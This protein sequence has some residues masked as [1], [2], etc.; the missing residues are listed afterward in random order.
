LS[1][2]LQFG[3]KVAWTAGL[4]SGLFGGLVGNQGGIRSAALLG[5]QLSKAE[6]V[7]TATAIGIIVD[8]ARMPVYFATRMNDLLPFWPF[9]AVATLGVTAGTLLGKRLL[10]NVPE[11]LF[12]RVVSGIILL[13]GLAMLLKHT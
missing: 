11:S 5:F 3:P 12:K 4:S 9:I 1:S 8:A 7:A 2:R 10:S 13:L 6:F